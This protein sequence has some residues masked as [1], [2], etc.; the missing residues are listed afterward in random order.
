MNNH[1]FYVVGGWHMNGSAEEAVGEHRHQVRNKD[2][3]LCTY[4]VFNIL[5]G[6]WTSQEILGPHIESMVAAE[7]PLCGL[8]ECDVQFTGNCS[9]DACV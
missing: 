7:M 4:S 3:Q 8:V 9:S 6:Q 5:S 2:I 1:L